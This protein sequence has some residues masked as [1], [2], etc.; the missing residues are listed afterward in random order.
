M[1]GK[2]RKIAFS[3]LF[4]VG[5]A[6]VLQL[7]LFFFM[8]S[9]LNEYSKIFSSVMRFVSMIVI[10]TV[11]NR[12]MAAE[13][14]IPW[15]IVILILPLFGTAMYLAFSEV[16]MPKKQKKLFHNINISLADNF[17]DEIQNRDEIINQTGEYKG[18]CNYIFNTTLQLP[19]KNTQTKF[20]SVGEL[21][22]EDLLNELNKAEKYIFMEYFIIGY[23]FMWDSIYDILCQKAKSGVEIR[24]MYDDL[25]SVSTLK[26]N[27]AKSLC[28]KQMECIKFHPFIPVISEVHNNRDHRKITV[29]DGRCAFVGGINI[30]DEYINKKD[31]FGHWKDTA[32][33]LEGEGVKSI[34]AMFLQMYGIQSGK[35]DDY[36]NYLVKQTCASNG[37]VV[38]F[39]DGPKPAYAQHISENVIL[40]LINNAKNYI[41]ISTPYLIIDG[42][43]INALCGASLRGVDVRIVTP[44]IP[45][46]EIIFA[47][48]R[49][50]Y[51][52]LQKEGVRILEYTPGFIHAKQIV[53]DDKIAM[54]GTVNLDYRSLIHHYECAVLLVGTDTVFDIKNDFCDVFSKS[55]DM[56][57]FKQ[58]RFV[59]MLCRFL[60]AFTPLL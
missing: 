23:G 48:T 6:I 26:Y 16:K 58:N 27:F 25:G 60:S 33:K 2:L 18:L 43:M 42:K 45:D 50:Y 7:A 21:F 55:T 39:G 38:P 32:L 57:E 5:L 44:H 47:I 22:F 35:T 30:A 14:K 28:A 31:R 24:I 36:K 13:S 41:W 34:T 19:Y 3:R 37:I 10:I 12:N 4:L 11:L 56:K 8:L 17:N 49:S 46:K 59:S 29:I 15:I 54:V 51:G 40:N 20:Y 1:I 52:K 53:C 9:G